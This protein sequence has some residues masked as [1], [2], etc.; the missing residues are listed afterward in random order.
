MKIDSDDET[1]FNAAMALMDAVNAHDKAAFADTLHDDIHYAFLHQGHHAANGKAEVL[2]AWNGMMAMMPDIQEEI[3]EV[4]VRKDLA[5][6][7]WNMSGRL[8]GPLPLGSGYAVPE[9]PQDPV[10]TNGVDIFLIRDGKVIRKDTLLDVGVWFE[11]FG[12]IVQR[13]A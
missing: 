2:D 1:T 13:P 8:S 7:Y 9:S 4:I 5:L 6:V 10:T 11:A 3:T 12:D